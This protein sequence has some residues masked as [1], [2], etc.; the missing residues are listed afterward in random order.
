MAGIDK[1][2]R[3]LIL[4]SRLIEGRKIE[5]KTFCEDMKINRRTFDRDIED[6]R[7]CFSEMYTGEEVVYDRNEDS[8]YMKKSSIGVART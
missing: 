3:I 2:T 1:V 6:I 4:Y 7:A 8:Y 5:K